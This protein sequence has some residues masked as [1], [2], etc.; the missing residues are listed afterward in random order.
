MTG[1]IETRL[2]E[3]GLELPEPAAPAGSYVPYLIEDKL[4]FISGQLPMGKDGIAVTGRLGDTIE[5]ADAQTAAKIC[6][7]NVIAQAKA[8]TGDLERIKRCL[9]LGGFVNATYDFTEHPKVLNGASELMVS[10]FGDAGRHTRFA[11]GCS[12][13]PFNAPVEVEA[14][15]AIV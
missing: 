13:L 12:S 7:L 2:H 6:A 15:F 10:I 14:L 5:I 3:L 11:V 9:K 1:P 8:A 4:L